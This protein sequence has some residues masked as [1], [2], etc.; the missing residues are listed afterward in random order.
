MWATVL[1]RFRG[2]ERG[3]LTGKRVQ[4]KGEALGAYSGQTA[5]CGAFDPS[6]GTYLVTLYVV[7]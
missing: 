4:L 6:K 5:L 3:F 1:S 2:V 7:S